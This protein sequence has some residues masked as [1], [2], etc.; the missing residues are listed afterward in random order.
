MQKQVSFGFVFV[1]KDVRG[2]ENIAALI[3][4]CV[5]LWPYQVDVFLFHS[6]EFSTPIIDI[7]TLHNEQ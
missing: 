6:F 7:T 3:G 2:K 4:P 5:D 1:N